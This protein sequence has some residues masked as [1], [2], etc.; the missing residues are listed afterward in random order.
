MTVSQPQYYSTGPAT[1]ETWSLNGTAQD[2][3]AGTAV[4]RSPPA[5]FANSPGSWCSLAFSLPDGSSLNIG[6]L[7]GL[8]DPL[9][10]GTYTTSGILF[11][12][13]PP[14]DPMTI[15]YFAQHYFPYSGSLDVFT[16]DVGANSTIW[17][18]AANLGAGSGVTV[19]ATAVTMETSPATPPPPDSSADP[20]D[21]I[22]ARR[23]AAL[24]LITA[25]LGIT[26]LPSDLGD[27]DATFAQIGL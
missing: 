18:F 8:P 10:I 23:R 20:A 26:D 22:D 1:L 4:L 15:E 7:F 12:G 25:P 11:L 3:Q 9:D 24:S 27:L 13:P 6:L 2:S 5:A 16:C 17:Q 14:P 19:V 21:P